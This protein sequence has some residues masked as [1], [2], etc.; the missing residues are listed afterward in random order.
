VDIQTGRSR[1][2]RRRRRRTGV[3]LKVYRIFSVDITV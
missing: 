1:R 3:N 2:K